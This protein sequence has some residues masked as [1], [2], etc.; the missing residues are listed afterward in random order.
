MNFAPD[1]PENSEVR[2][3]KVGDQ[4]QKTPDSAQKRMRQGAQVTGAEAA[5]TTGIAEITYR[6]REGDWT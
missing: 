4:S 5:T 6:K 3:S 2:R 1:A